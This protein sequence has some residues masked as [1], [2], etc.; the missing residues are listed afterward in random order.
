MIETAEA[1]KNV[2]EIAA[3][4][5]VDG[6]FV[7]PVDLA[8]SLGHGVPDAG[9]HAA[10]DQALDACVTAAGRHGGFVGSIAFDPAHAR[11]LL[12]RGVRFA[13]VGN[14]KAYLRAA[15][16]RDVAAIR[17]LIEDQ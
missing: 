16:A 8:I 1:L 7:G 10:V 2:E 4:P 14:D 17:A 13:S 6:L 12:D 3:V 15:A 5:G 11:E 9:R